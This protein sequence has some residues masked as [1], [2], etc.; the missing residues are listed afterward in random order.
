M[1]THQRTGAVSAYF[2]N[3]QRF[4]RIFSFLRAKISA[5]MCKNLQTVHMYS[6]KRR[7]FRTE[8]TV[9]TVQVYS[10]ALFQRQYADISAR[11]CLPSWKQ[12]EIS[13]KMP[14]CAVQR[15]LAL[16]FQRKRKGC[17]R[18]VCY[19]NIVFNTNCSIFVSIISNS[20]TL[21]N[22]HLWKVFTLIN[23]D[24]TEQYFWYKS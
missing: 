14:F 16:I 3:S 18:H 12:R 13:A 23:L 24:P 20:K 10:F 4:Q 17:C 21:V 5:K 22:F 19:S 6:G 1:S 8:N 15:E 9:Q 7:H 2:A 11:F